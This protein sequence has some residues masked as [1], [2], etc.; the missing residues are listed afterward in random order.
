MFRTSG[1]R[2]SVTELTMIRRLCFLAILLF[3][4]PSA[5]Q[6]AKGPLLGDLLKQPTYRAAWLGMVAGETLPPWL[7][8]YIKTFDGPAI[9]TIRIPV[10]P[11]AYTLGFTCKPGACDVEQLYALFSPSG[12]KA[13]GLLLTPAGKKW[14]GAPDQA[15]QDAI[16]NSLE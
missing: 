8:D 4:A 9:P 11:D 14:L 5:A 7:D 15:V 6:D 1:P 2:F 12:A 10:G 13:W 16:L 3:A